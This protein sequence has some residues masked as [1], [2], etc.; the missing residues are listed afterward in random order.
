MLAAG[1]HLN[2]CLRMTNS[3]RIAQTC[4]LLFFS[5]LAVVTIFFFLIRLPRKKNKMI[6][7][8]FLRRAGRRVTSSEAIDLHA[9]VCGDRLA[10]EEESDT[11]ALTQSFH[12]HSQR[13]KFDDD[14]DVG[15]PLA[16]NLQRRRVEVEHHDSSSH[17]HHTALCGT[18]PDLTPDEMFD[19]LANLHNPTA[20]SYALFES[21][22]IV[23]QLLLSGAV[24]RSSSKAISSWVISAEVVLRRPHA[25]AVVMGPSRWSICQ[26]LLQGM[27]DDFDAI[28]SPIRRC[29]TLHE[30]SPEWCSFLRSCV[31]VAILSPDIAPLIP[32]CVEAMVTGTLKHPA[33]GLRGSPRERAYVAS[34]L[35]LE[36]SVE[37]GSES[38]LNIALEL[39]QSFRIPRDYQIMLRV[40]QSMSKRGRRSKDWQLRRSGLLETTV[41]KWIRD[42][43]PTTMGHKGR[44][45][46]LQAD[47]EP[48][49]TSTPP[50]STVS[51][52]S[53]KSNACQSSQAADTASWTPQELKAL[54]DITL[55]ELSAARSRRQG[56]TDAACSPKMQVKLDPADLPASHNS[57]ALENPPPLI[58]DAKLPSLFFESAAQRHGNASQALDLAILQLQKRHKKIE[59]ESFLLM[60]EEVTTHR[61]LFGGENGSS[62][63]LFRKPD[64]GALIA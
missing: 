34:S 61:P 45:T 11:A 20:Y 21:V 10:A 32:L 16:R 1:S 60:P 50:Q 39:M 52:E 15:Q 12:L 49:Q 43:Y 22:D 2:V 54:Y 6:R 23:H 51:D 63:A 33:R 3:A 7:S 40:E 30:V 36:S 38:V 59:Q 42:Y 57:K 46:A 41:P 27:L 13:L 56:S 47:I 28:R 35:L 48:E 5:Q 9:N 17:R 64:D 62:S 58:T 55:N 19:Q 29:C 25:L 24:S 18:M 37:F 44:T 26:K 8:Y 31:S 14:I 53:S 4:V